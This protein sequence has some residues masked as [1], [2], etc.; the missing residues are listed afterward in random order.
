LNAS[1]GLISGSP[2]AAGTSDFTAKV[3]DSSSPAQ[4]QSAS[5]SITINSGG[6]PLAIDTLT[7]PAG[8]VGTAYSF[9]FQ[10]SGGTQPYS[11]SWTGDLP[12][13]ISFDQTTGTFSGTPTAAGIALLTFTVSSAD[14]Q[15]AKVGYALQVF[16]GNGSNDGFLKGRYAFAIQSTNY[17]NA[18]NASLASFQ[19]D[20]AGNILAGVEDG[21]SVTTFVGTYNVGDDNRGSM[22]F[23]PDQA[24][25][26]SGTSLLGETYTF[27]LGTPQSAVGTAGQIVRTAAGNPL[28]VNSENT[29]RAV[30]AGPLLLQDAASFTQETLKGNFAF[31]GLF[32]QMNASSATTMAGILSMNGAG[33]IASTS[34]FDY[35]E[36]G[37][38]VM[39]TAVNG[40]FGT[41]DSGTGRTTATL[42]PADGSQFFTAGVVVYVVNS[43]KLFVYTPPNITIPGIGIANLQSASVTYDSTALDSTAVFYA[44]ELN[45][46]NGSGVC[47][48]L[49]E[50]GTLDFATAGQYSEL[51]DTNTAGTITQNVASTGTVS[52]AS[53]GRVVGAGGGWIAYLTNSNQGFVLGPDSRYELGWFTPQSGSP[54]STGSISGRY[55]GGNSTVFVPGT[56]V[57]SGVAA[58]T[59]SG[60]LSLTEDLTAAS[61]TGTTLDQTS[62]LSLTVNSTSGR[63]TFSGN[64]V[65]YIVSPTEFWI[66]DENAATT[67]PAIGLWQQ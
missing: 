36:P 7:L 33:V 21:G 4:S 12:P 15:S 42:V 23:Y 35:A 67:Y 54:F 48:S 60:S 5:L 18:P 44:G 64:F 6:G 20:G 57:F 50:I 32:G 45:A 2:T 65:G 11:W 61:G 62:T 41:P 51:A 22:T 9:T 8:Y 37:V 13:G 3:T 59:T 53:D 31:A 52:V 38:G 27:A 25:Q 26:K 49:A 66:L 28:D 14:N 10:V 47:D 43:K 16:M 19:A 56:T 58:S 30:A 39:N 34:E 40:T 63:I 29:S 55:V 17:L 46:C 24:S 1:T